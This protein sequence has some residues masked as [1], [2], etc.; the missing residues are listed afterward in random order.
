RILGGDSLTEPKLR[1]NIRSPAAKQ[2]EGNALSKAADKKRKNIETMP[3]AWARILSMKNS[4]PDQRRL[5]E[6]KQAMEAG[7]I[8]RE[9]ESAGERLAKAEG[10]RLWREL[11]AKKADDSLRKMVEHTSDNYRL[12]TDKSDVD[13]MLSEALSEELSVFDVGSTGVD[14]C[15]GDVVGHV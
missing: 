8:G 5:S 1:L 11:D 13:A 2:G 4:A 3:E 14:G 10:L 9:A 12:I 7:E 15:E 6:V